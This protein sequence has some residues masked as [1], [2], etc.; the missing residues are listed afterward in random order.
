MFFLALI[1]GIVCVFKAYESFDVR[2]EAGSIDMN[3][4]NDERFEVSRTIAIGTGGASTLCFTI[5]ILLSFYAGM[6]H[7][8]KAPPGASSHCCMGGFL[9]AA[10]VIFCL[11][12]INELI[13]LVLAFNIDQ[14]I[15]PE[16]VWSALIG[17]IL[18][19]MLMFGYSE[20]ARRI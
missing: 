10:C 16:V 9:I 5:A 19:W 6:R 7:K 14:V 20:M 1:F 17:S 12:F 2:E 18:S 3:I 15:Y 11:T 8:E 4:T 13:V